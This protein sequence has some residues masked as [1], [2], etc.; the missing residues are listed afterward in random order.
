MN[1]RDETEADYKTS[2]IPCTANGQNL[3]GMRR[4]LL[5]LPPLHSLPRFSAALPLCALFVDGA[6]GVEGGLTEYPRIIVDVI[7]MKGTDFK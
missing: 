1:V 6:E 2:A 4:I 5:D 3:R 7:L